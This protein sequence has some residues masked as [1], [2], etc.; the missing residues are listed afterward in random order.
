[1]LKRE[2]HHGIDMTTEQIEF[3]HWLT[4][5]PNFKYQIKNGK[6]DTHCH[7]LCEQCDYS[8]DSDVLDKRYLCAQVSDSIAMEYFERFHPEMLL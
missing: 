5:S 4:K 8:S 1:M 2:N 7:G 3:L 6:L